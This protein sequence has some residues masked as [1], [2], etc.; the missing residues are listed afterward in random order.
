LN[1]EVTD[2]MDVIAVRL[3]GARTQARRPYIWV[4]SDSPRPHRPGVVAVGVRGE[5]TLFVDLSMSPDVITIT[6]PA[7]QRPRLVQSIVRQ[8]E[9]TGVGVTIVGNAAGSDIPVGAK[10]VSSYDELVGA[11][12][13]GPL[14]VIFG[15]VASN[16]EL[17]HVRRLVPTSDP[18]TILVIVG[19]TRRARWSIDLQSGQ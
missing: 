15:T 9:Q 5:D 11:R 18:R 12:Q 10:V 6:G 17:P 13:P 19:E 2:G 1:T 8:L 14:E 16:R 7:S 4:A 3:A